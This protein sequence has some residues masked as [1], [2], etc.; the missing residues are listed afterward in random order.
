MAA[1][2]PAPPQGNPQ[3]PGSSLSSIFNFLKQFAGGGGAAGQAAGAPG[4]APGA[5]QTPQP[6]PVQNPSLMPGQPN[7]MLESIGRALLG[8]TAGSPGM[9]DTTELKKQIDAHMKVLDEQKK[10]AQHV[11][12][13]VSAAP[14]SPRGAPQSQV[15]VSQPFHDLFHSVMSGLQS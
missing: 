6:Q 11:R 9:Q 15:D 5:N 3:N 10:A 13:A 7:S 2:S 4:G 8:R 14:A 12:K 1:G